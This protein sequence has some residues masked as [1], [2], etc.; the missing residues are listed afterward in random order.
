[1]GT[2]ITHGVWTLYAALLILNYYWNVNEQT[3][4]LRAMGLWK[5]LL[6]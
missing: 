6:N 4:L 3:A 2:I 5:G 1:M